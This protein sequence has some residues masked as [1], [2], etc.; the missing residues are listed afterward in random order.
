MFCFITTLSF[1]LQR[2]SD[3]LSILPRLWQRQLTQLLRRRITNVSDKEKDVLIHAGPGAGKTLGAL[4]SFKKM[5]EEGHLSNFVVF[6]HRNSICT[7]WRKTALKLGLKLI[8]FDEFSSDL[9]SFDGILTTYQGAASKKDELIEA[10]SGLIEGGFLAIAD[11]AHHLGVNPEEPEKQAWGTTF[12]ELTLQSKLR[13][14]LTGTPFRSDNLA[15]CAARKIRVRTNSGVFEQINP[16]LCIEPRELIANGDVRPIEFRF[17]DGWVEHSKPGQPDRELSL[18]SSENRESWRA[19][20]LRRCI[21]L[22]DSSSIAMQLLIK[23]KLQLQK[24]REHHPNAAGLVISRDI[25]HAKA[26]SCALKE[27]GESVELVHSQDSDANERLADFQMSQAKWLVSVDMCSEGFDSPRIRVVAYLTTVITRSR[28]LQG[29]TRAVRMDSQRA[30]DEPI[31]RDPSYVF[32]PADPV[33][34]NHAQ[35]WAKSQP[36]QIKSSTISTSDLENFGESSHRPSLPLEAINDGAGKVIR[37]HTPELP[38][39]LK[40]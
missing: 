28:F 31:P 27:D 30:A 20:N 5:K 12:L 21:R 3:K 19:R 38:A 22:S 16:D 14:G 25:Q 9:T 32:A 24:I 39:F 4:M 35:D 11:E 40:K 2:S 36:Y 37:M 13:L 15:F 26:I 1:E 10:F 7:Q 23:A 6:C 33:L 18:I 8:D 29:I 34:I 17:Q